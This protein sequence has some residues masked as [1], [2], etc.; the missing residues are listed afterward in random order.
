[1]KII[2]K[3]LITSVALLLLSTAAYA[4]S[5]DMSINTENI[6]FSKSSFMQ[7]QKTRIYVK[8]TN[9]SNLD[10]LGVVRFYAN[11]NQIGADQAISIFAGKTDGVFIDWTPGYGNHEILVKL[12]PFETEIDNPANNQIVTNIYVVQD[13]D[14]DGIPNSSDE[15]D[16]NDGVLDEEDIFPLLASEQFDTDGDGTGDNSDEDDDNDGVP[17]EFD[18]LPLDPE[19]TMD[20]DKDGIGNIADTDDDNDGLSDTEEENQKTDPLKADTDEDGVNDKEDPF[21]TNPKEWLDTDNDNIGDNTDTDDDN[22]GVNDEADE[23]PL[24]KGPIIQLVDENSLISLFK[25]HTFDASPSY[26]EDGSIVSFYWE[27]DKSTQKEGNAIKHTFTKVGEHEVSLTITDDQGEQR[28][29]NFLVSVVNTSL[30]IQFAL[31]IA[32]ILLA[33]LI[34]FKYIAEA[35]NSQ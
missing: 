4:F 28:T 13:T 34:Y 22:D 30:Y 10:L 15:D 17:D 14:Y 18:D 27:I 25:N 32:A 3:S 1:M 12:F 9:N 19:E 33:L 8:A 7:G 21:P 31:F 20:T 29:T 23:F 6:S 35:E 26:D 11:G 24:N 5:G 16:D 2:G